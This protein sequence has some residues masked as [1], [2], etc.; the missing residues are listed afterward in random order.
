MQ[1]LRLHRLPQM[2]SKREQ[3]VQLSRMVS[4]WEYRG[5]VIAVVASAL[6][7]RMGH[8]RFLADFVVP[9]GHPGEILILLGK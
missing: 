6:G 1:A 4:G 3:V 8:G 5:M 7:A 2:A 9:G